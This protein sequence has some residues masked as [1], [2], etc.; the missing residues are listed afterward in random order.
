MP[1]Y[2]CVV[3]FLGDFAQCRVTWRE[4][5]LGRWHQ[6]G[7]QLWVY[8]Q[9]LAEAGWTAEGRVVGVTQPRRVAAVTVSFSLY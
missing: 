2:T 7:I 6:I 3:S 4:G 1:Q 5:C 8:L 9:Y